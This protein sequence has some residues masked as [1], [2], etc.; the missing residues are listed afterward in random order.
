MRH[1]AVLALLA[2]GCSVP[3]VTFYPDDATNTPETA[4][5][6]DASLDGDAGTSPDA[7]GAGSNDAPSDAPYD[8]PAYCTPDG[9]AAPPG[10]KCCDTDAQPGVVCSGPCGAG[11]CG[12]CTGCALPDICCTKGAHGSCTLQCQ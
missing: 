10:T 12:M 7:D 6:D 11:A 3:A 5:P 1:A 4:G 9:P 2:T 8:G